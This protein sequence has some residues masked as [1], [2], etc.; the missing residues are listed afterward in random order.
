MRSPGGESA[1]PMVDLSP[2]SALPGV[3]ICYVPVPEDKI[4]RA[5][6]L[7]GVDALV[8]CE[9]GIAAQSFPANRRLRHIARFGVGFDDIA[10]D[11]ATEASVLV[12]NAPLGLRRPMAVAVLM[13]VLALA[14]RLFEK[15]G[16][17][18][19]GPDGWSR[20]ADYLGL[21]LIGR[22]LG[23]VGLGS[24]GSE[25]M[26]LAR[27]FGFKLLAHDPFVD[28]RHAA[29]LETELVEMNELCRRS[30]FLSINCPLNPQTAGLLSAGHIALMKPSS[31][32]I[33]TSRGK[34][35]D[36]QALTSAL[37]SR[38]IAGAAL[39]VFESEPLPADDPLNNLDNVI[40][41]PHAIGLTDQCF[42]DTGRTN[43]DAI[44]TML[45]GEI[46]ANVLNPQ[47]L[48]KLEFQQRLL[49]YRR[50]WAK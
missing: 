3:E 14:N 19:Q 21:G 39:D 8:L 34:I 15:S 25:V 20:I 43:V 42:A 17:A 18:R 41:T 9:C 48:E 38:K 2:L 36:Q 37:T 50:S 45:K 10:I 33:N 1:Y 31:Y 47:V 40:I 11:A 7:A 35:V 16:I 32:L 23:S 6:D 4:A 49:E 24:I 28:P 44:L 27:P 22:T 26:Q 30:D 46:P 13:L 5:E 29:S 12:T